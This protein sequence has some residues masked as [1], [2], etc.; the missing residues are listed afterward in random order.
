MLLLIDWQSVIEFDRPLQKH[1]ISKSGVD[2]EFVC[3]TKGKYH[4]NYYGKN[5]RII[6]QYQVSLELPFT[7]IYIYIVYLFRQKNNIY[8]NEH[9][10]RRYWFIKVQEV[11]EE[12][13]RNLCEGRFCVMG[14]RNLPRRA[15]ILS[16]GMYPR[17][18]V[19]EVL[20]TGRRI[21]F[22]SGPVKS[23][24]VLGEQR[25]P[26]ICSFFPN[27]RHLQRSS[28]PYVSIFLLV[29]RLRSNHPKSHLG[30]VI[31]DLRRGQ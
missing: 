31:Q 12:M 5:N 7:F 18:L 21:G 27:F 20:V 6:W 19:S 29:P 25:D 28:C 13:V 1:I 16:V 10:V 4:S 9:S 17:H 26:V 14:F 11:E 3:P 30:K 24:D 8:C 22:V 2:V 23:I 15:E